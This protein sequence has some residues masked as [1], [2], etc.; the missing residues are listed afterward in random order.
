MDMS[1]PLHHK[2]SF[3][4]SARALSVLDGQYVAAVLMFSFES[5]LELVPVTSHTIGQPFSFNALSCG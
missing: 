1:W 4:S 2:F 5:F 3:V